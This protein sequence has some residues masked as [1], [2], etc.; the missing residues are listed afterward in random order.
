MSLIWFHIR[1][2]DARFVQYS[3]PAKLEML[4]LAASRLINGNRS[5]GRMSPTGLYGWMGHAAQGV[6][7]A[8]IVGGRRLALAVLGL[9]AMGGVGLLIASQAGFQ[10]DTVAPKTVD[11]RLAVW[12]DRKSTRLNSSHQKISY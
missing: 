5:S 1:A 7:L 4:L 2:N 3:I 12:S 6:T 9:L 8:L 10:T 11:T